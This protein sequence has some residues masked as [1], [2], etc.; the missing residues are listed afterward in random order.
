MSLVWLCLRHPANLV[1]SEFKRST[2]EKCLDHRISVLF[3]TFLTPNSFNKEEY[4]HCLN[5]LEKLYFSYEVGPMNKWTFSYLYSNLAIHRS[6]SFSLLVDLYD[7]RHEDAGRHFEW[8]GNHSEWYSEHI[9]RGHWPVGSCCGAGRSVSCFY[10]RVWKP[11]MKIQW[12]I[13]F[14]EKRKLKTMKIRLN[15]WC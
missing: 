11:E 12:N 1:A 14:T 6:V 3:Q 13:K 7:P 4:L 8:T 2:H 5:Y 15:F 9:G 10:F